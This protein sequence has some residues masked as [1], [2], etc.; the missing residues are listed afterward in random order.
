MLHG[1]IVYEGHERHPGQ[2]F[3]DPD[4]KPF[5]HLFIGDI[6]GQATRH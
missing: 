2:R 3:N 6:R 5:S 1:R 4:S